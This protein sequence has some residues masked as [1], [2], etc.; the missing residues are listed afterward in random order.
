MFCTLLALSSDE[1]SRPFATLVYKLR[2]SRLTHIDIRLISSTAD[3]LTVRP[4]EGCL[5]TRCVV[6]RYVN[7]NALLRQSDCADGRN[8]LIFYGYE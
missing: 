4:C 6:E 3:M 8:A 5:T 7:S 1:L 2:D